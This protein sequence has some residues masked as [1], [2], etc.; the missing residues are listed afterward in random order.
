MKI[1]FVSYGDFYCNSTIHVFGFANQLVRM[2]HECAVAVPKNKESV[3]NLGT[4][5]F[6][7]CT[8]N[9]ISLGEAPF[10]NNSAPDLIHCWTPREI[11]RKFVEPLREKWG[12]KLALHLEDNEDRLIEAFMKK[13]LAELKALPLAELDSLIPDDISHPIRYRTFLDSADGV[14]VIMDRLKEFL[15]Y[16]KPI[17]ILWPGVDFERFKPLEKRSRE[18]E[19]PGILPGDYVIAYTG[20]VHWVNREDVRKLYL[21]VG[22]LNRRGVPTKLL[23]SG[24]DFYSFLSP[25]EVWVRKFEINWGASNGLKSRAF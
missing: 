15:P 25:N 3:S 1:L 17:E 24:E 2:G 5:L 9:E 14:S 19:F 4:P 23:R 20:H 6:K 8:F 12:C 13:P 10:E 7:A 22:E 11:V 21:A 18:T 16:K